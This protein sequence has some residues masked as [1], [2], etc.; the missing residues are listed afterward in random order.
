MQED[1][2][3]MRQGFHEDV[4]ATVDHEDEDEDV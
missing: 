1:E 3:K 2:V 4:Y